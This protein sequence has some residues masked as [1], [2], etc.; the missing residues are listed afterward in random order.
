MKKII[1]P[2]AG[3]HCKSC[4]LLIEKKLSEIPEVNKSEVSFSKG[5][6]EIYYT[7]QKPND[8]EVEEAIRQ[9]GYTIGVT[10][11]LPL[12]SKHTSDYKDLGVA[13]LFLLGIYLVLKNLGLTSINIGP[14]SNPSSLPVVL[15]IGITAGFSTCMALVGGLILGISAR[16]AE[17]HPEAT[18][19]QKVRPHLFFNLGRIASYTVMGGLLGALGSVLQL[20]SSFL[21]ILT[22]GVG[23]VMLLMGLKLT[24]IFPRLQQ[25]NFTLP[26]SISRL[27]GI[28]KHEKEYSHTSAAL[29]GALTFFLPCGFTQAMQLFAVSTGSFVQGSLIMGL[30]ALGTAPGLLGIGGLTSA[31]KGIFAQRFFK[32][33][34]IVVVLFAL[35][36]INNGSN[37]AGINLN[38]VLA[39]RGNSNVE[40]NDP[41]VT[42]ENGVQVVHMTENSRGY[43]PNKFTIQKDMPVRWVITAQD[44]YSC[45]SSLVAPK[46]NIRKNLVAGENNIEFTPTETGKIP[47][48]CS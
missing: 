8:D 4:E 15:F 13:F 20:S 7:T 11:K 21:G 26:K 17:K 25:Y 39:A 30:F 2:I 19:R 48:S 23:I 38:A 36:N 34:G 33:D 3:M 43:S 27:F 47:F 46:L 40:V 9:T 31:V 24:G 22:I 12:F 14:S 44:P 5:T 6:A 37:L 28:K 32:F 41:N 35:F 10:G 18:M 29:L 1:V 16:H 45:A 42:I